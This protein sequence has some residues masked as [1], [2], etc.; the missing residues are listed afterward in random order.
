[1]SAPA[2]KLRL[3]LVFATAAALSACASSGGAGRPAAEERSP[4]PTSTATGTKASKA[5]AAAPRSASPSQGDDR[6]EAPQLAV[7]APARELSP[8]AQRL[9]EEAVAAAEEQKRLKVPT[10]WET[11][12]RRWR[13]VLDADQVPEAWFN[14]GVALE[15]QRRTDEARVAY[16]R[17]LQLEPRLSPAAANLLLLDEPKEPAAAAQ[18]WAEL[19]RL[20]PEEPV[21][22][23]R[24]AALY[25]AAG[26]HGEAWKL[27]REALLRDPRSVDA[28]KVMLRVALA[29]GNLDLANLLAVKARKLDPADPELIAIVGDVLL[30]QKD[31][32]GA[33]A[34][35]KKAVAL[36]DDFLPARY[37][38]L[39]SAFAKHHW[40]GVAEQARAILRAD[41]DARVQL[42]L[43]VA[44]RYLGKPDQALAAYD[45]AE[46]LGGGKL[47]E[48][49]LA[50]G[51]AL[52]KSKEQCEPALV[53][54][55][56]Y[57]V[58]AGPAVASEGPARR[59]QRE[60][61]QILLASKEAEDAAREM[62][63]D[64]EREAARK[65]A[66]AASKEA[67][68]AGN[69][70]PAQPGSPPATPSAPPPGARPPPTSAVE[71]RG[72]PTR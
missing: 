44:L 64:A 65:A 5:T 56:R 23:G 32:P 7:T 4:A 57:V 2:M 58:A 69:A 34:Q 12:E 13:A 30:R 1:M 10:D 21:A 49:H 52:M 62:K 14:L 3:S 42:A 29:R 11:L 20:F 27:A 68:P 35:W 6:A 51:V 16:Q 66:V 9:F 22:R 40:E 31:E 59:L 41:P 47:P 46:K 39:A 17:A 38:L 15:K 50:R 28:Y 72:A 19:A 55:R 26:Q 37:A 24:L 25:E 61:E 53:E 70:S 8:R 71:G 63:A 45:Q 36:R 60:C 18:R 67:K 33:I 48:V 43:G 54:L